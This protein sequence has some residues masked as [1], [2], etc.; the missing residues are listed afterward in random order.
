MTQDKYVLVVERDENKET[1]YHMSIRK[2][3]G[4]DMD[5]KTWEKYYKEYIV[6]LK[7]KFMHILDENPRMSKM[8][9]SLNLDG[10]D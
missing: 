10:V 4:G 2:E 3:N 9:I 7:V 5:K 6:P 8:E 1:S